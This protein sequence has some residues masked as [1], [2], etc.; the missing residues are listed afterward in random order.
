MSVPHDFPVLCDF[1][2]AAAQLKFVQVR[3]SVFQSGP[4]R[5]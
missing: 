2:D 5:R 1:F 4:E 3:P